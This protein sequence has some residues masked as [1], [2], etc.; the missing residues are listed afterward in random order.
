M[1]R[2]GSGESHVLSLYPAIKLVLEGEEIHEIGGRPHVL[3]PGRLLM[4]DAGAPYRTVVRRSQQTLGLCIYMPCAP[5]DAAPQ[6]LIL[7]RG[8][9]QAADATT[10]GRLVTAWA[11]RLHGSD[12]PAG[13]A[14]SVVDDLAKL[15]PEALATAASAL[16]QLSAQRMSTRREALIRLECARAHLHSNLDRLISLHELAAVAGMSSFHLARYFREAY[17][18]A[19]ARYHRN[20]RLDHAAQR[21]LRAEASVTQVALDAGY[22]Q[23]SAFTHAFRR[24]FGR[25]PSGAA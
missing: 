25:P 2:V 10:L 6:A 17:G 23:L 4:V 20:L 13:Q 16:D 15:L 5:V 18:V 24:H 9:L 8:F 12:M 19:P 7:G 22:G 21:L 3:C 11:A 1:S 14:A